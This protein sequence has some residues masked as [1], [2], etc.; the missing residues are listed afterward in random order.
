[1]ICRIWR[2]ERKREGGREKKK[3]RAHSVYALEHNDT[4]SVTVKKVDRVSESM[5]GSQCRSYDCEILVTF[6]SYITFAILFSSSAIFS[7]Y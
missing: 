1:M 5:S 2:A 4:C 6:R 7:N 3:K